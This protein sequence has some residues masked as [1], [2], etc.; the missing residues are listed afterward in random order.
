MS[1][2]T[3][4]QTGFSISKHAEIYLRSSHSEGSEQSILDLHTFLY[5]IGFQ[6]CP[7]CNEWLIMRPKPEDIP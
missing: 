5:H 1:K 4:H 2:N 7:F 6:S 3:E